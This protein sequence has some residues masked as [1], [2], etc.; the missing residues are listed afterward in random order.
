MT[1]AHRAAEVLHLCQARLP[2]QRCVRKDD[3]I[4][5]E[6]TGSRNR[7]NQSLETNHKENYR[8]PI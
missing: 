2:F 7:N 1:N 4:L 3:A 5:R 6:V 8:W